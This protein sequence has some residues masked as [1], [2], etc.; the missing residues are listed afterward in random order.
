MFPPL[1][2]WA[3]FERPY[4][5]GLGCVLCS[6]RRSIALAIGIHKI[7]GLQKQLILS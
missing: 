3:I 5:T 7:N 4:G 1:K 2:R 6:N